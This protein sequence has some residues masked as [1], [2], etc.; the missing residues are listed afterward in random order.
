MFEN[1]FCLFVLNCPVYETQR[2]WKTWNIFAWSQNYLHQ[3]LNPHLFRKSSLLVGDRAKKVPSVTFR[4]TRM[5]RCCHGAADISKAFCHGRISCSKASAGCSALILPTQTLTT[6]HWQKAGWLFSILVRM[7]GCPLHHIPPSSSTL[8]SQWCT[9]YCRT[10]SSTYV[11]G[12][13]RVD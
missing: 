6:V 9:V 3:Q 10:L 1:V 7:T 11:T 8:P 4:L 2:Q 5:L 12:L 13:H